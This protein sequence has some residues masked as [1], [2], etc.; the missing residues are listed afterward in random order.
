[1]YLLVSH[2]DFPIFSPI[3]LYSKTL[4]TQSRQGTMLILKLSRSSIQTKS[5]KV[6]IDK[7]NWWKAV[8][9]AICQVIP[10]SQVND[11]QVNTVLQYLY[12]ISPYQIPYMNLNTFHFWTSALSSLG[13]ANSTEPD[14]KAHTCR[15]TWFYTGGKF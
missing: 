15:M 11:R 13:P 14:Q 2:F 9:M 6:R 10:G 4:L 8:T 1:M 12:D 7:N 3:L 5:M